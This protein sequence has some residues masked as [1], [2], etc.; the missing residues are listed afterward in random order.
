M[1]TMTGRG[2]GPDVQLRLVTGFQI[3][4]PEAS[5]SFVSQVPRSYALGLPTLPSSPRNTLPSGAQLRTN[6]TSICPAAHALLGS[7]PSLQVRCGLNRLM[8]I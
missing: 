6:A 5:L 8:G 1:L 7:E 2:W 3:I 4:S